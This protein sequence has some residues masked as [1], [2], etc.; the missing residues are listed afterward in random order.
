MTE[1]P[2]PVRL[3]PHVTSH[4]TVQVL[5]TLLQEAK[6]GELLGI[7]FGVMYSNRDLDVG[8]TGEF[9]RNPFFARCLVA[10]LDDYL[11][12]QTKLMFQERPK[13]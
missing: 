9:D 11:G 13:T 8:N 4:D 2:P 7:L 6:R 5:T 1:L 10:E 12:E 3:V